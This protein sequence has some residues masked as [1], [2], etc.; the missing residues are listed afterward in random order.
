MG[1]FNAR[2]GSYQRDDVLVGH[3]GHG[4][5]DSRGDMLVEFAETNN[6]HI[7]NYF[8][9][10]KPTRK[11]TWRSPSGRTSEIDYILTDRK[12]TFLNC[13]VINRFNT[14]SNR[15]MV[16]CKIRLNFKSERSK[17]QKSNARIYLQNN[18]EFQDELKNALSAFLDENE[19]FSL[20]NAEDITNIILQCA[21][22]TGVKSSEVTPPTKLS[23]ATLNL[24]EQRRK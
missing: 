11:W 22:K 18:T 19:T 13:K 24:M 3:F 1:D 9:Q 23:K 4:S 5:K 12:Y 6:L 2:I 16:R 15:R 21:E 10:H 8:F 14:G 7:M 17:L 20:S